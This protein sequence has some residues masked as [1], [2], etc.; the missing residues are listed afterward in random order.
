MKIGITK[1]EARQLSALYKSQLSEIMEEWAEH[2]A[3]PSGGYLTDFGENWKLV[4]R[5]R[6]I[7]AQ[8]RTNFLLAYMNIPDARKSGSH[9]QRQDEIFW[10]A[11]LMRGKGDGT[12]RCQRM[13]KR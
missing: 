13:G 9:W 7:W 8:A 12:M 11:M 10:F 5:R 6:N 1:E 2:S 3:D 4:S